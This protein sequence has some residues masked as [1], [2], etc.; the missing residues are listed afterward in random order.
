LS[1][2]AKKENSVLVGFLSLHTSPMPNRDVSFMSVLIEV[3][4]VLAEAMSRE[5]NSTQLKSPN[6]MATSPS[7]LKSRSFEKKGLRKEALPAG[8]YT[9]AT[10]TWRLE[11]GV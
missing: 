3:S 9:P 2:V 11:A 8:A 1:D 4:R 6:D 5:G 7:P 10:I